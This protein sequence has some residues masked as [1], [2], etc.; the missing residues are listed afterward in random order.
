MDLINKNE[1]IDRKG[2]ILIDCFLVENLKIHER[3]NLSITRL[4][5]IYN[6]FK[7]LNEEQFFT[8]DKNFIIQRIPSNTLIIEH[9]QDLF[10]QLF[11]LLSSSDEKKNEVDFITIMTV[12]ET[13]DLILLC[14]KNHPSSQ[15]KILESRELTKRFNQLHSQAFNIPF[16]TKPLTIL[17]DYFPKS[18]HPYF[19]EF[20]RLNIYKHEQEK[21]KIHKEKSEKEC[22]RFEYLIKNIKYSKTA[23]TLSSL[24]S[25]HNHIV[26]DIFAWNSIFFMNIEAEN[27]LYPSPLQINSP[28]FDRCVKAIMDFSEKLNFLVRFYILTPKTFKK[29]VKA[30]TLCLEM[31]D[32]LIKKEDLHGAFTL[33][34]ALNAP[35]V[36]RLQELFKNLNQNNQKQLKQY[37]WL[38][39]NRKNFKVYR[40]FLLSCKSPIPIF[41]LLIKDNTVANENGNKNNNEINLYK[42]KFYYNQYEIVKSLQKH[43]QNNFMAVEMRSNL[44]K[45]L[46]D[47]EVKA[48]QKELFQRSYEIQ[49]QTKKI[50]I[51]K[52]A[53]NDPKN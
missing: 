45:T 40:N 28:G 39:S 5:F 11:F 18:K 50:E 34:S 16:D 15:K 24:S 6:T 9:I 7:T 48:I 38:F 21:I 36:S 46:L 10:N 27:F 4:T 2:L 8:L 23:E 25:H 41:Q 30:L 42:W 1:T 44:Y 52:D 20:F 26:E 32:Q 47:L 3:V 19:K 33:Y 14:L 37:S 17:Q 31:I 53:N 29:R 22:I 51:I 49:P 12:H 35:E 43:N 13:V